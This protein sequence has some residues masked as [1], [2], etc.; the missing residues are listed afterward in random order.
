MFSFNWFK[1]KNQFEKN[2]VSYS[3]FSTFMLRIAFASH[4]CR[5]AKLLTVY[6]FYLGF[7]GM[8]R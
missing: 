1:P 8:A 5:C 7:G 4:T 6:A 3:L 2:R